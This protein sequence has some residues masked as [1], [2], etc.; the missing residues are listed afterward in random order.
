[1]SKSNSDSSDD[2]EYVETP[3]APT[4]V[5]P[6]EDFGVKTTAVSRIPKR[7]RIKSGLELIF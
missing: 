2:F 3:A 7:H 5:P 1:M 6:A 4:P